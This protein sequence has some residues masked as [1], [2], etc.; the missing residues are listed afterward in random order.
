MPKVEVT[1]NEWLPYNHKD[2]WYALLQNWG[3][4][5]FLIPFPQRRKQEKAIYCLSIIITWCHKK[6]YI[7]V[8]PWAILTKRVEKG[9]KYFTWLKNNCMKFE[10]MWQF[11]HHP[12]R[13]CACWLSLAWWPP[14]VWWLPLSWSWPSWT[15]MMFSLWLSWSLAQTLFV[16]A[17][18]AGE[19]CLYSCRRIE[20][21]KYTFCTMQGHTV[22]FSGLCT[23]R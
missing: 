3:S 15:L 7:I 22:S 21:A 16:A 8:F 1:P 18:V 17:C 20:M 5:D 14:L 6:P 9:I 23:F 13:S 2:H 12:G 10:A 11:S 19:T 4:S